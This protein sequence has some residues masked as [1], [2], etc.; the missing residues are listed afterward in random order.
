MTVIC[1]FFALIRVSKV[2]LLLYIFFLWQC[3]NFQQPLNRISFSISIQVMQCGRRKSVMRT[4]LRRIMFCCLG[5]DR[6]ERAGGCT[7]S[8][9]SK[10][11]HVID[12]FAGL[13]RSKWSSSYQAVT[14]CMFGI[15]WKQRT[16]TSVSLFRDHSDSMATYEYDRL[17]LRKGWNGKGDRVKSAPLHRCGRA[18]RDMR[19]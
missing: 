17:R 15:V 6:E 19:V 1:S 3:I 13:L 9:C 16:W 8:S 7:S 4:H 12:M 14:W 10:L 18:M 11:L 2:A 5:S